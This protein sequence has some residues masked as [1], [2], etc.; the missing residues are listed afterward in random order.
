MNVKWL[1]SV[2]CE[3]PRG[4]KMDTEGKVNTK[5][6]TKSEIKDL[7]VKYG[8]ETKGN[9]DV[10][11]KRLKEYYESQEMEEDDAQDDYLSV[12]DEIKPDDSVSNQGSA[13]SSVRSKRAINAAKLRGLQVKM[14]AMSVE[15]Q[16]KRQQTDLFEQEEKLKRNRERLADDLER[17]KLKTEMETLQAEDEALAEFYEIRSSTKSQSSNTRKAYTPP[18][19]IGEFLQTAAKE[20]ATNGGNK[21]REFE[22]DDLTAENPSHQQTSKQAA[23]ILSSNQEQEQLAQ[24]VKNSLQDA[25]TNATENCQEQ[26]LPKAD[27]TNRLKTSST[28]KATNNTATIQPDIQVLNPS[29][30]L[31]QQMLD[32]M[33]LPKPQLITFDGDPLNFHVFLNIARI[34]QR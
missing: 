18:I 13:V 17:L 4:D 30:V 25:T 5:K 19:G 34:K 12:Q 11:E 8:L 26:N 24:A 7:L 28:E 10:L 6:L 20:L 2:I 22:L 23:A 31:Q 21:A 33:T 29:L 15:Q 16:L 3:R 32:L 9:K 27:V 1:K 14:Q